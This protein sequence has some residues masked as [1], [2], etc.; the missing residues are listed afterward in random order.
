MVSTTGQDPGL[1]GFTKGW[2]R[3]PEHPRNRQLRHRLLYLNTIHYIYKQT[4]PV[5]QVD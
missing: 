5:T 1:S 4:E 3:L 2:L